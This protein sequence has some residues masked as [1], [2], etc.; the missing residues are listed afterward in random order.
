[1]DARLPVRKLFE[2]DFDA[3]TLMV[4]HAVGG[5]IS[6]YEGPVRLHSRQ[7]EGFIEAAK[8]TPDLPRVHN[9][10]ALDYDFGIL[11]ASD[12]CFEEGTR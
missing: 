2:R 4:T 10:G 5:V 6:G 1:M 11:A 12:Y 8:R 9:F 7:K 3:Q